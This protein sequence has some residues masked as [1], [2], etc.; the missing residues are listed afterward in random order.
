MCLHIGQPICDTWNNVLC[1]VI[2]VKCRSICDV[3]II[4][5]AFVSLFLAWKMW[6]YNGPRV[7]VGVHASSAFTSKSVRWGVGVWVYVYFCLSDCLS[8]IL[9]CRY[10]LQQHYRD[11]VY[12][13]NV[14]SLW[15]IY[16][17]SCTHLY[18]PFRFKPIND[19]TIQA[20]WIL[21][22]KLIHPIITR[23]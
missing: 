1:C 12:I 5:S 20:P 9:S 21:F 3:I 22:A 14:I 23:H 10:M 13:P 6:L 15:F 17:R 11:Y 16:K 19:V 8:V 2:T 4:S 18:S 7:R